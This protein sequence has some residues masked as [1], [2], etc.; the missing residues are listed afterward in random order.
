[1]KKGHFKINLVVICLLMLTLFVACNNNPH[2]HTYEEGWSYDD[3]QHWKKATCEHTEEK[4]ELG[5]H[6]WVDNKVITQ[7]TTKAE[8]EKEQICSVCGKTRNV[9]IPKVASLELLDGFIADKTYNKD[10]IEIDKTKIRRIGSTDPIIEE[11]IKSILYKQQ[12][13][14]KYIEE[15]PVEAGKYTVKVTTVATADHK[16]SE[17][18]KDFTISPKPIKGSATYNNGTVAYNGH[19]QFLELELGHAEVEDIIDGDTINFT[20][21][22]FS[23]DAGENKKALSYKCNNSNYTAKTDDFNITVTMKQREITRPINIKYDYNGQSSYVYTNWVGNSEIIDID[24]GTL[25][26]TLTFD[27]ANAGNSKV[28]TNKQLSSNN[29]KLANNIVITAEIT[30]KNLTLKN[31]GSITFF[32]G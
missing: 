31:N 24:R 8:G 21:I 2:V 28:I 22:R 17:I 18:T 27:N 12:T 9:T 29:Y 26:L 4:A 19:E 15:A 3:N 32:V 25:K 7:A 1:M 30:P 16:E 5:D 14:D 23:K 10:P 20:S 11:E 13:D 6:N